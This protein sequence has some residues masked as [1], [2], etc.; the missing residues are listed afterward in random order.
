VVID[1][2]EGTEVCGTDSAGEE[3]TERFKS[4]GNLPWTAVLGAVLREGGLGIVEPGAPDIEPDTG[5]Q[6]YTF[7][8]KVY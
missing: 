1:H 8:A 7:R 2:A 6:R 3:I 5:F 4:F